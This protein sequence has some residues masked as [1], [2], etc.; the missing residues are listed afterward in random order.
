MT[1]VQTC[2]FRSVPTLINPFS[3][4][5]EE[6][7]Q[8]GL[9][10]GLNSRQQHAREKWKEFKETYYNKPIQAVLK[11]KQDVYKT[12][13]ML[14][15]PDVIKRLE[16]ILK[17]DFFGEDRLRKLYREYAEMKIGKQGKRNEPL[18][19]R[20]A[21][22]LIEFLGHRNEQAVKDLVQKQSKAAV[23][24]ERLKVN[25][26]PKPPTP[27]EIAQAKE[28]KYI[29]DML[30]RDPEKLLYEFDSVEKI[31]RMKGWISG[32]PEGDKL[33][34]EFSRFKLESM[35]NKEAFDSYGDLMRVPQLKKLIRDKKA[36]E[37]MKELMS[38]QAFK[39]LEMVGENLQELSKSA[40]KYL[41]TSGTAT[42][43]E[44]K[45]YISH[46]LG[47]IGLALKGN[48][49]KLAAFVATYIGG[50]KVAANILTDPEILEKT[51]KL[52]LANQQNNTSL[53]T[54]LWNQIVTWMKAQTAASK[55]SI[56]TS[57][58][59]MGKAIQNKYAQVKQNPTEFAG[60]VAPLVHAAEQ[61]LRE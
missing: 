14:T 7:V 20:E 6:V 33:F 47:Y 45:K 31:R 49:G 17:K 10:P 5:L 55:A 54:D 11:N 34:K 56:Q 57:P 59:R 29:L 53:S 19:T 38:P 12:H 21:D 44:E 50:A 32:T 43:T 61:G 35:L 15:N 27:Q 28:T 2:L 24:A 25:P 3:Y 4:D 23:E 58:Q 51:R 40:A 30:D 46:F 52:I 8:R 9:E 13:A 39:D 1:G 18:T 48:P 60:K 16:P 26:P 22:D 37:L 36:R 42:V 41:N